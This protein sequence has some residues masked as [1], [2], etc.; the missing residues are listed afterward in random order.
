MSKPKG[1]SS[2][3]F[4][5][6]P[7]GDAESGSSHIKPSC[8]DFKPPAG[9]TKSGSSH[10]KP[11]SGDFKPPAG[12]AKSGS[13]HIEPSGGV[14]AGGG[15]Q[16]PLNPLA[17]HIRKA[18]KKRAKEAGVSVPHEVAVDFAKDYASRQSKRKNRDFSDADVAEAVAIFEGQYDPPE[19]PAVGGGGAGGVQELPL[20]PFADHIRKAIKKRA[21]EAGVFVPHEVAVDFAK[22]YA[23]RQSKRKNR[24]FSDADVTEAVAI[25]E[26]Q[27][28]P[29]SPP[30]VG[31]GAAAGSLILSFTEAIFSAIL[32]WRPSAGYSIPDRIVQEF[33]TTY[34]SE[35]PPRS[36]KKFKQSE[37][38]SALQMFR[39]QQEQWLQQREHERQQRE[40]QRQQE[41]QEQREQ[42]QL[43]QQQEPQ[44]HQQHPQHPQ[45]PKPVKKPEIQAGSLQ[46]VQASKSKK[47][48]KNKEVPTAIS[49]ETEYARVVNSLGDR[50]F[51]VEIVRSGIHVRC[52]LA[53]AMPRGRDSRVNLED[54]V[55]V[56]MRTYESTSTVQNPGGTIIF[57]Y[58]PQEI[59][60]LQKMGEL[61][62]RCSSQLET[63]SV[64]FVRTKN[65]DEVVAVVQGGY[66][67]DFP[68]SDSEDDE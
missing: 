46:T 21:K 51:N 67:L 22:D 26:G 18:I 17:D 54:V 10:I 4:S 29:P 48:N 45:K 65:F 2:S 14:F 49:E 3:K 36:K 30:A 66:D 1:K 62:E 35:H 47:G 9:D 38:N 43:R 44:Q 50:R 55:L 6:P 37:V 42:E 64:C 19:S 33:A 39:E 5:K 23:S 15:Q 34:A 12:D 57:K 68:P 53:G 52:R 8:G 41:Q 16:L 40:Q 32:D 56:D 27:Y 7:V 11:S 60:T 61:S 28:E 58:S 31:G 63:S 59:R 20:S 24:D 13:S 25:F